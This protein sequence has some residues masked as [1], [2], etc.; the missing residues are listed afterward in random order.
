MLGGPHDRGTA[1]NELRDGGANANANANADADANAN[2]NADASADAEQ[3]EDDDELSELDDD[4]FNDL[5]QIDREAA[6]VIDDMVV[7]PGV[8]QPPTR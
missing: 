8:M 6:P 5:S 2:A 3:A 4:D 7:Q 1:A